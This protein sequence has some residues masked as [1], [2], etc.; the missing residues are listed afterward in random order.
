MLIILEL[1]I[2]DVAAVCGVDLLDGQFLGVLNGLTVDGGAAGD[3]ADAADLDGGAGISA[4]ALTCCL[5]GSGGRSC[6]RGSLGRSSVGRCGGTAGGQAQYHGSRQHR[7][8][9]FFHCNSLLKTQAAH[10]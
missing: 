8:N 7:A 6:L 1:P 9:E 10:S 2:K 5:G 4:G 3:R